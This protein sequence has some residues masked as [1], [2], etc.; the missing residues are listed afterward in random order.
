M[1]ECQFGNYLLQLLLNGKMICCYTVCSSFAS[2]GWHHLDHPSN[3]GSWVLS[4][5]DGFLADI[6]LLN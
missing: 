2:L 4:E 1:Q 3:V 5:L 6:S